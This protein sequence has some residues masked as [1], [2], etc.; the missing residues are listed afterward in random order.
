M[1]FHHNELFLLYNPQTSPGKQTKAM[2]LSICKNV[3]EVNVIQEKLSPMYWKEIV[4]MLKLEPKKLLDKS[5][6]DYQNKVA[7][8]KYTM[9]GWLEV[10]SHYPHLI[11]GPIAIYN[12]HAVFCQ[13]PTDILKL[14]NV[15]SDSKILP[16]L[17]KYQA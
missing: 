8:N 13:K 12:G 15:K 9:N 3:N 17:R 7:G 10:L 16:H 1:Q 6:L 11:K 2:A 4:N 14:E 5:Q